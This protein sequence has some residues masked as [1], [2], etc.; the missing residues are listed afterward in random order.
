LCFKAE[1]EWHNMKD[2][3]IILHLTGQVFYHGVHEQSNSYNHALLGRGV[4][5]LTSWLD[6]NY[7]EF[8][9]LGC[10]YTYGGM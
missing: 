10:V 9:I 6:A 4:G 2:K 7:D 5:C 8:G 3:K 1:E